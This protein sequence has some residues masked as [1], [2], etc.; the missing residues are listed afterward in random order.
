MQLGNGPC[1]DCI[2]DGTRLNGCERNCLLLILQLTAAKNASLISITMKHLLPLKYIDVVEKAGSIR[3]AA[4]LL[5]ITSTALNRRILAMEQELG[6]AIFERMPRGV[7]LTSAGEILI[8][9]IRS[10]MSDMERVRSQIDDL[11][12][13]R[14]GHINIACS[15]AVLAGFLPQQIQAYREQH[16]AVTFGVFLRDRDA[17]ER[18]LVDHS[19]DLA[20]VFEPV[21]LAELQS[22]LNVRQRI[23]AVMSDR[24]PLADQAALRLY[25][26]LQFPIAVPTVDYGV[27]VLLEQALQGSALKLKPAIESDSFEFL[28]SSASA[29]DMVA[30]EIEIGQ[31]P[32]Y[33]M[34]GEEMLRIPLSDVP[35]GQ[36]CLGQLRG[37]TLSVAAAQFANQ[38]T[39]E[40]LS[41]YPE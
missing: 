37:R 27:R 34:D 11:A 38:I 10:Q 4:E 25:D 2:R 21:R 16:P 15:Q 26:C 30:F 13:V 35:T 32:V 12:G 3:K 17:A 29:P 23:C 36:L 1:I 24:H 22:I 33:W 31:S 19:A 8:H 9:H 5:S 28:R 14:R 6:V 39:Q 41:R 18:A 7:R 40:L 20:L